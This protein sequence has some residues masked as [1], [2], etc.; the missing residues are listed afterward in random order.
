MVPVE[1]VRKVEAGRHEPKPKEG[2]TL[3]TS[4]HGKEKIT[5]WEGFEPRVYSDAGGKLTIGVGH[6]LTPSELS[7]GKIWIK[8][9]AVRYADRLSDQQILDL[10]G[11]DLEGAEDAVNNGVEVDLSQNQFDTLVSFSFNVGVGAFRNSTLRKLLN[12][13]QYDDVP[14]QL[15][16]WVHCRGKVVQGLVRRREQEIALWN[17]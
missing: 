17:A 12:R 8:G 2:I 4:D 16:R 15:H 6:L 7:S 9:E 11:Q 13:G 14:A 10:L 1:S 5:A 3:K